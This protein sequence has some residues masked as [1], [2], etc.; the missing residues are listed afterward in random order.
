MGNRKKGKPE[1]RANTGED[2]KKK[3]SRVISFREAYVGDKKKGVGNNRGWVGKRTGGSKREGTEPRAK[4]TF[5]G[6]E[7]N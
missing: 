1:E 3:G 7:I 2:P 6:N 4:E 5:R